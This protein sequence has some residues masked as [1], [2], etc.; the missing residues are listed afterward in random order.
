MAKEVKENVTGDSFTFNIL[1]GIGKESK[2]PYLYTKNK[3]GDKTFLI[4]LIKDGKKMVVA[5]PKGVKGA[6]IVCTSYK[7]NFVGTDEKGFENKTE[8]L[9]LF[10]VDSV[11]F[12]K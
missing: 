9:T 6:E 10:N 4:N 12:T 1:V 3:K 11:V 7:Y 8:S 5:I 2:Q